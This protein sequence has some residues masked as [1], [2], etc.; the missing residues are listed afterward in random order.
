LNRDLFVISAPSGTGKTTLIRRLLSGLTGIDFSVSFTTRS[1]REGEREGTDYHF[2]KPDEFDRM[3]E[4]GEFLEWAQVYGQRYGT[5]AK[6]VDQSLSSGRDVL[7]D[8]D[9]QGAASV[10]RL[11][12][13]AVLIF[14]LPPDRATLER[15]LHG[16]GVDAPEEVVRR[17]VAAR[18]EL[19]RYTMYD[20][21]VVNDSIEEA[22]KK[23][24]AIVLAHRCRRSRQEEACRGIVAGFT[25]G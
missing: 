22:L 18:V 12:Q 25:R 11:R 5:S 19:E 17:L 8:I 14:I 16:R 10:R 20:Y 4:A 9:T 6:R 7:L 2:V 21:I 3:V 23:L 13:D 1:R 24:E 15:R